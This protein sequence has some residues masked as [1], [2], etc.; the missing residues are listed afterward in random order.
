MLIDPI[1][2]LNLQEELQLEENVNSTFLFG[3]SIGELDR[4]IESFDSLPIYSNSLK[5]F[6]LIKV[7]A[8]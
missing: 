3:K 5:L 4:M 6:K 1:L 8:Q 2:Q 7:H